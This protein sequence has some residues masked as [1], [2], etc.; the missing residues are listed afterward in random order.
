MRSPFPGFDPYV[1]RFWVSVHNKLI[2][3]IG[4]ALNE[5]LPADLRSDVEERVVVSL[6]D[7][8]G[9]GRRLVRPDVQVS[10]WNPSVSGR[11][12]GGGRVGEVLVGAE[13]GA[14][15]AE[16]M[17]VV[18][19]DEP[20]V[21]TSLVITDLSGGR[22][23]TTIEVL[24]A[25]NKFA[26]PERE[27]FLRKRDECIAGGV[28]VVEIDLYRGGTRTLP[29]LEGI[30]PASVH[31]QSLVCVRPAGGREWEVYAVPLPAR[32]PVFR[33]PL[34]EGDPE[35]ALD[36]QAVFDRVYQNGRYPIDYSKEAEPPLEGE[37]GR[38]AGEVL[39]GDRG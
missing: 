16:P 21:E 26:G 7:G 14:A 32:L 31:H 18:L 6:P 35:L 22:V 17:R 8:G 9:V 19:D 10:V 13:A 2:H 11:G 33:L 30:L 4:F 15:V 5:K 38:W 3:E 23:V 24:S 39:R 28:N 20:V 29:A 12:A 37:D 34:R 25:S 36:L 27:R 1:Q